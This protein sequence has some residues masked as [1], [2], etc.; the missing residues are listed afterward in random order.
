MSTPYEIAKRYGFLLEH[1]AV[2]SED[3]YILTIFRLVDTKKMN[4]RNRQPLVVE[5]G[6]L[7]DGISWMLSGNHS[8]AFYFA[9]AGFDVWVINSR[10]TTYSRKHTNGSI[11]EKDYWNF[12]FH[13]VAIHDTPQI[14]E[15]ISDHTN[16]ND[17]IH[18]AH[19]KGATSSTVYA[20]LKSDHARKHVKGLIQLAPVVTI[21]KMEGG[22]RLVI[23]FF[24][25]FRQVVEFFGIYDIESIPLIGS[26]VTFMCSRFPTII[27]C[28]LTEALFT[29]YV[30][31]QVSADI[32]PV[33]ARHFPI[34]T[35]IKALT[36]YHQII[37]KNGRFQWFDYGPS[38]NSNLYN[39]TYP[40]EYN[41]QKVTLPVHIIGGRQDFVATKEDVE[42]FYNQLKKPK[43][44]RFVDASHADFVLGKQVV[45]IYGDIMYAIKQINKQKDVK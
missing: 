1:H 32:F 42:R 23:L 30:A 7:L 33:I 29:G 24:D 45:E 21:S 16:R 26:L 39:S 37:K 11:S 25:L 19:S 15:L 17:I 27:I 14:M 4:M 43:S 28:G 2:T 8:L 18:I 5:H 44:L 9:D 20:I 31:Q 41:L 10:G 35:S 12:S 36:H 3:G 38:I 6:V 34:G 13:E 40:P 22:E